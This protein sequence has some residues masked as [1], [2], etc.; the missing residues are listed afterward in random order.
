[1]TNTK[2]IDYLKKSNSTRSFSNYIIPKNDLLT[3]LEGGRLT[4][5]GGNI[6]P[7]NVTVVQDK[8]I[9]NNILSIVEPKIKGGM[10]FTADIQYYP[11]VW[12]KKYQTR[13]ALT[14]AGFYKS[15]NINRKN[16]EERLD[17]WVDNFKFFNSSNVFFIHTDKIFTDSSSGML[18]DIGMFIE[19]I[20]LVAGE[21]GYDHCIQGAI[22]EYANDI[23]PILGIDKEHSLLLSISL[24]KKNI[25]DNKNT[26]K[27][28]RIEIEEFCSFL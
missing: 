17:A 10:D 20:I 9:L 21:L 3:I 7:W 18:I 25:D 1:M 27:P 19:N 22:G 14:G 15:A 8:I 6:Q 4:S 5:S 11:T 16:R 12:K 26:F 23:K 2:I 13:R 28:E 24:G